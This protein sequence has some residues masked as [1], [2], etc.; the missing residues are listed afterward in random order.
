MMPKRVID[1]ITENLCSDSNDELTKE[2]KKQIEKFGG[3]AF[4]V[5]QLTA[6]GLCYQE[7][8]TAIE[9]FRTELDAFISREKSLL[10]LALEGD[11][12]HIKG[13][14]D[15]AAILSVSSN[16]LQAYILPAKNWS[17]LE[18]FAKLSIETLQSRKKILALVSAL[19]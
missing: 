6:Q 18:E 7:I 14:H 8:C 19:C 16:S 13:V 17:C 4:L 3:E 10:R 9:M 2:Q 11:N 1:V 5:H 12:D 15:L